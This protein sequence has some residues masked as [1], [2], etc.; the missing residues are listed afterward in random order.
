MPLG[1]L[2]FH[3]SITSYSKVQAV[4]AR[5]I[6]NRRLQLRRRRIAGAAY[7]D[8]GCGTNAHPAFINLDYLWHPG[9]DVCWDVA[10]GLPFDAGSL[11]GVYSEHCLEHFSMPDVMKLLREIRRV[12]R[13]DGVARIVVPDAELYLRTYVEHVGGNGARSFPFQGEEQSGGVWTP[14]VSVNRV[15]YQDRDSPFGH[16]T[17]FD[18]Q[19]LAAVLKNAGFAHVARQEFRKGSDSTLL[20]DST[21]R[22]LESLYV[23]AYA[24]HPQD[25]NEAPS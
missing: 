18:F 3:R 4:V 9:V 16:R 23:E 24:L 2:S 20:I 6:R 25:A 22:R 7:L 8:V 19:L 14:L 15:F 12:L 1:T 21:D 5:L 13:P 11:R 10:R 17:M